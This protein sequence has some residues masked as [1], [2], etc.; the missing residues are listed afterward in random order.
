M[1]SDRDIIFA[2]K[3]EWFG[4]LMVFLSHVS[5]LH[6][7]WHAS[8]D[9]SLTTRVAYTK[10]HAYRP[11]RDHLGAVEPNEVHDQLHDLE[12]AQAAEDV[13]VLVKQELCMATLSSTSPPEN[14][15]SATYNSPP[16]NLRGITVL[17]ML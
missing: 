5:L 6:N 17:Q 11:G 16:A 10:P 1:S 12:P 15:T 3:P 8:S 2:C 7:H 14:H 4:V 9:S 13:V